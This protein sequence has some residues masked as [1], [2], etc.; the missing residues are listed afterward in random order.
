M[1]VS[2]WE[3]VKLNQILRPQFISLVITFLSESSQSE[4]GRETSTDNS[5]TCAAVRNILQ[6]IGKFVQAYVAM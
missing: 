3:N 5:G 2:N 1:F 4:T 6:L